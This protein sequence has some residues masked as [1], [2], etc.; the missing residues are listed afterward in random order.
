MK[1][2]NKF[3]RKALI[4]V[5][6]IVVTVFS[7]ELILN[8]S[9]F[10]QNVYAQTTKKT[11]TAVKKKVKKPRRKRRI[12]KFSLNFKDVEIKEFL[13]IMSQL[14]NKNIIVDDRVRGKI[15]V[16]SAK[17]VPISR[18]YEIMKSILELKGLA[19]IETRNLIKIIPVND[20][21]KKNTDIIVDGRV[22][23]LNRENTVTFLYEVKNADPNELVRVLQ[24]LKS[25]F[26]NIVTYPALNTIIFSGKSSEVKGLIKIAKSLD[27]EDP[28]TGEKVDIS[29]GNIHVYHLENSKANQIAEVLS[30]IPFSESA[31]INR[32]PIAKSIR[33]SGKTRRTTSRY[34]PPSRSKQKLSIIPSKETNSLII[35]AKPEEYREILRVIKK[36]DIVREQVLIEALIVEVSAENNWSFGIDWM[37]GGKSGQHTG[38]TSQIN[39]MSSLNSWSKTGDIQ[40]KQVPL[41]L[42]SGFQLGYLNNNSILS[43]AIL[44]ASASDKDVN[45]LSTPQILTIDN[46]EA[47]MNVGED[48]SVPKTKISSGSDNSTSYD[49]QQVGLK[50]KIT[51]HI[52]KGGQITLDY[53]QEVNSLLDQGDPATGQL[54]KIGRR[55]FKTK[56]TIFDGKTAV[57][58]GLISNHKSTVISKVP[59]L[60]DI[61]L[62]GWIFKRK[63]VRN[64]KKNLMVFITPH[65]VTK[66]NRLD[67]ITQQKREEQRMIKQRN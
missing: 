66:Q 48:I 51:P 17:E 60:G 45:V 63:S 47:E 31:V 23:R 40:G 34:R 1:I 41:P 49:Y 62:L 65:I 39:N 10:S 37:L 29:T 32:A 42:N 21:I 56:I 52:T 54:P 57:V 11:K 9:I 15:T 19:V 58:G 55:D 28:D 33:P 5:F 67:A 24:S 6:L 46:E 25:R 30:R 35:Y 13:N 2:N 22:A 7:S 50:L 12:R 61:P 20:A 53:Y 18:A 44:N 27:K 4:L 14:I 3:L 36:L 16:N 43:F 8:N 59:I 26:T 64:E 38:A